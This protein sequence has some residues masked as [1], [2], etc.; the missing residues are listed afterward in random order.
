MRDRSFACAAA[1]ADFHRHS[2]HDAD[3]LYLS[4]SKPDSVHGRVYVGKW[5]CTA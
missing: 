5:I 2:Y 1:D 3:S 4:R